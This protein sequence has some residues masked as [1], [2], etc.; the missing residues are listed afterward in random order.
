MSE[1]QMVKFSWAL[2]SIQAISALLLIQFKV[3]FDK[4]GNRRAG[5]RANFDELGF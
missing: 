3:S 1:I 4:K 5:F 2:N